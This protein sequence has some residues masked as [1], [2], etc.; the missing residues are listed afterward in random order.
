MN[1]VDAI[2]SELSARHHKVSAEFLV[3]VRPMVERIL[4]PNTPEHTRVPL[5]ELLAETVERDVKVRDDAVAARAELVEFFAAIR[6]AID[7]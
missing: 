2:L 4:D 1:R 6:R 3:A 5:L 7:P